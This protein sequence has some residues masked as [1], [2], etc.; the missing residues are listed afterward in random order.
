MERKRK[1]GREEKGWGG[2]QD[3]V[4]GRKGRGGREEN[5]DKKSDLSH[6]SIICI[7]YSLGGAFIVAVGD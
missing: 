1:E 5:G 4:E 6:P 7:V 2:R 3:R